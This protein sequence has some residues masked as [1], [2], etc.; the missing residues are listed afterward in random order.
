MREVEVSTSAWETANCYFR[1]LVHA[2]YREIRHIGD[3]SDRQAKCFVGGELSEAARMCRENRKMLKSSVPYQSAK[4]S[5]TDDIIFPYQL[6]TNLSPEQLA[7]LFRNHEWAPKYGGERWAVITEVLIKLK[8]AIDGGNLD[9][10]VAICREVRTLQHNSGRLIP[11]MMK[12]EE[13]AWIREK[14]PELCHDS[15]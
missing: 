11:S 5:H 14:W 8:N 10:A 6:L 1:N 2:A 4:S 12:W 3:H 7:N 15:E 13:S 9:E